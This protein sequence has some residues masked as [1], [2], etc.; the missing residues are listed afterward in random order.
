MEPSKFWCRRKV[1][2][3]STVLLRVAAYRVR[4]TYLVEL[5]PSNTTIPDPASLGGRPIHSYK[6]NLKPCK[7]GSRASSSRSTSCRLPERLQFD[8]R[9]WVCYTP[10]HHWIL[11][12]IDTGARLDVTCIYTALP[13]HQA[14]FFTTPPNSLRP[15]TTPSETHTPASSS[16]RTTLVHL[17][18]RISY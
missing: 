10:Y 8:S 5:K 3:A 1:K 2:S 18:T 14:I 4:V 6:S 12:I 16:P 7:T 9:P 13:G 11:N 17:K 15:P